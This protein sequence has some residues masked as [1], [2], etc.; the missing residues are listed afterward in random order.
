MSRRFVAGRSVRGALSTAF[1]AS[2]SLVAIMVGALFFW[3]LVTVGWRGIVGLSS[4]QPFAPGLF[5][6]LLGS[7][8]VVGLAF[9]MA[10]PVGLVAG[11]FIAE[12]GRNSPWLG[13]VRF[14]VDV[15]SGVPAVVVGVFVFFLVGENGR[16]L[17]AGA[18]A[19]GV[20]M[21]PMLAYATSRTLERLSP[22]LREAGHALGAP[23]WRTLI[24]ISMRAAAP[25]IL[26]AG[27]LAVARVAGRVAP[28]LLVMPANTEASSAALMPTLHVE[29]Y[30]L[31]LTSDPQ[32]PSLAWTAALLLTV[33]ITAI[34]W[35][36]GRLRHLDGEED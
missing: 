33:G 35:L 11:V 27:L 10:V 30:R 26:S 24:Q 7:V 31:L 32:A 23:S 9:A 4:S 25:G 20:L 36:A 2:T 18:L 22:S 15:L 6:A 17:F 13:P 29:A 34:V 21:M 14:V 3:V 5:D 12:V 8:A 19:L 1:R 28:L 16:G